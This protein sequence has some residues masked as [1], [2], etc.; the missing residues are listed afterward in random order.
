M[1]QQLPDTLSMIADLIARPSVSSTQ[2]EY[3]QSNLPVIHLLAEWMETLGFKVDIQSLSAGKANLIATLGHTDDPGGLVLSGHTDTVPCN[4]DRWQSDPFQATLRDNRLYGL[5]T[6]DMKSFFALVLESVTRFDL[7][8]FRKPLVIL[9][10]ADE[11]STMHGAKTL[12]EQNIRPGR[13]AVI[14]EPTGLKPVRMHKGIMMRAVS[15]QGQSGHSSNPGLGINAIEGMNTIL[16]R[17]LQYR[18]Y[19]RN[20]HINPAFTVA[21]PTLNIGSIHG[22]DNPNRICGHCETHFDVRPLPGMSLE[23]LDHELKNLVA[24]ALDGPWSV[25]YRS[26]FSGIP[27]FETP[28]DALIVQIAEALTETQAQAVDF[29]TEAPFLSQLGMETLVMGPGYIQQAHQPDEY[30]PLEHIHPCIQL[31]AQLIERF[32]VAE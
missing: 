10:T 23:F 9:A 6:A 5:G 12:L 30:L 17:L 13:Y 15:V 21:Y 8:R 11:E 20:T 24:E 31:Y 18:D 29:A 4:P 19:L 28:S 3:D 2:T 32:C 7:K 25:H 1:N 26:L 16:N 14:G 27:A 22:G